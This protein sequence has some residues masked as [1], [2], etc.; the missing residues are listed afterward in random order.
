MI[1]LYLDTVDINQVS[2]L[3][4]CLPLKGVTTNPSILAK[5]GRGVNH[6][7]PELANVIGSEA[8][9]HIQ[10]VSQILDEIVDEAFKINS[11]PYDIVVKIPATE[12]GL[13][14]IKKIKQQNI[15]VLATAI[16]SVQQGILAALSGADYLAPYV[17]RMDTMGNDGIKV[18]SDLQL[19]LTQQDLDCKLLP[20]SF[21]N[22]LQVIEVM[23]LGVKAIT[24]PV[25]IAIQMLEHPAVDSA[26]QQFSQDWINVFGDKLSFES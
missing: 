20:A 22:T 24:I 18:V 9:F 15:P 16:Y 3:N 17:N 14:A 7:L 2:R 13:A 5:A 8:R 25:D 12:T 19:L 6:V 23:K 11:L 4:A 26:V 21:K 1:E 10:V